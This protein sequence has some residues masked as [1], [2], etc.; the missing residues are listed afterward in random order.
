MR[1]VITSFGGILPA[2]KP[3]ALP[4]DAAQDNRNLLASVPDFRPLATD[5]NVAVSGTANPKTLYRLDR[6]ADGSFNTDMSTG[7]VVNAA[8]VSYVKG[9]INNDTTERTYYTFDDGSAAPRWLDATGTDRIL[10]VPQPPLPTAVLSATAKF[11]AEDRTGAIEAA[12]LLVQT[13]IR[14]NLTAVWRGATEPGAG[15]TGFINLQALETATANQAQQARLYRVASENGGRNGALSNAYST[16]P[17]DG[18]SFVFDPAMQPFW[19]T[20]DANS[21]AWAGY[22]PGHAPDHIGV[23]FTAYG[24]TYDAA[25]GLNAALAAIPMPGKTDGTKLLTAAQVSNGVDGIVDRL[26]AKLSPAAVE[27]APKLSALFQSVQELRH[28]LNGGLRAAQQGQMTAFYAKADV[29]ALIA[30][31]LE[32]WAEKVFNR[33]KAVRSSA[34]PIYAYDSGGNPS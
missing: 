11:T 23:A 18:F 12:L 19:A 21:P 27:V 24:L 2:L 22:S 5:L 20:I 34:N 13:T 3:R 16:F 32:S 25:A 10:G 30:S 15:D 7:W 33:A 4:A 8:T 9:P 1:A 26:A 17:L 29:A 31:E 14:A 6:K 28:L